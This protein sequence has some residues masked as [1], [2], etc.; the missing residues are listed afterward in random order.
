MY[1]K[2]L[3]VLFFKE[4]DKAQYYFLIGQT[5]YEYSWKINS[6]YLRANLLERAPSTI[7]LN[8]K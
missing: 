8:G 2:N 1:F 4:A 5:I 3:I 6:I 7:I